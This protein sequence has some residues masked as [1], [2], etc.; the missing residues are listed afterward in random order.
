MAATAASE[1]WRRWVWGLA[2]TL[3]I[4]FALTVAILGTSQLESIEFV[5]LPRDSF[6]ALMTAMVG[7]V[8]L[9]V[10]YGAWQHGRLTSRDRELEHLVTRE[11]VLRE[12]LEELA[13]VLEVSGRLAQKLDLHAALRLAASR[14]QP[15][16]EAGY[17][18]VHLFNP[19]T[20]R[21]ER[22]VSSG[23]RT[24]SDRPGPVPANGLIDL[25]YSTG[26]V[27]AV[28]VADTE[29]RRGIARELGLTEVPTATLC[30]PVRF[31]KTRL[32]VF[33]IARFG[34][35]DPFVPMHARALQALADHVGAAIIQRFHSRAARRTSRAA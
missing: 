29:R 24:R 20:G 17:S 28:D 23:S 31:E 6:G 16:L 11:L 21:V 32:G 1:R 13:A 10:L 35:S 5:L 30:V 3:L 26:E 18:S 33:S 25:V 9:F 27:L 34:E 22:V 19:R 7:L 2:A 15:C 14:V 4:G 12:R 8:T